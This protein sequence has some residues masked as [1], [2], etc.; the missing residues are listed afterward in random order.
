MDPYPVGDGST[1][2]SRLSESLTIAERAG[3]KSRFFFRSPAPL[4]ES[5]QC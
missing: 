5:W 2:M 1:T 3:E 4:L